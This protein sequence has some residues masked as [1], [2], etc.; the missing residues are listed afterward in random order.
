M[1]QEELSKLLAT[2]SRGDSELD[3]LEDREL[4]VVS[5][6]AQGNGFG[7]VAREMGISGERLDALKQGIC[8]KLS[9]KS[10]LQLIRFAARQ[11]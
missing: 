1:T 6:L 9:L 5:L 3:Q 7:Q 11:V 4:E 8:R 10:D 2:E